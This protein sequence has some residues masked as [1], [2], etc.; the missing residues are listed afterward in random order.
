MFIRFKRVRLSSQPGLEDRYSIHAVLVESFRKN[1]Q[2]RQRVVKYLGAC[3]ERDFTNPVKRKVFLEIVRDRLDDLRIHPRIA[4]GIK[5]R[6]FRR[7]LK[8]DHPLR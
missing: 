7:S 5:V 1:G 4:A 3:R 8:F 2:P 6:M